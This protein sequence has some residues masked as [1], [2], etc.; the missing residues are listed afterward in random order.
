[1]NF[2][3]Q[4]IVYC[5]PWMEFEFGTR[6]EGYKI[7]IDENECIETT[8]QDRENGIHEEGYV[9]PMIPLRY[10]KVPFECLEEGPQAN[11]IG[12][13]LTQGLVEDKDV[14]WSSNNWEPEFKSK[15]IWIKE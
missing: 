2:N 7:F 8:K 9:G 3:S 15:T 4:K 6:K 12:M 11:I 14:T 5:V 10:F 1:M 13:I